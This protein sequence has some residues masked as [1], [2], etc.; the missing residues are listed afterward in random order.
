[1]NLMAFGKKNTH[2]F[3]WYQH[4]MFVGYVTFSHWCFVHSGQLHFYFDIIA[5]NNIV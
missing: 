1:M 3:S 4:Q 2:T 5:G